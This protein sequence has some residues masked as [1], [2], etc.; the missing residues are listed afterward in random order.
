MD[1]PGRKDHTEEFFLE[2]SSI[3][4]CISGVPVKIKKLFLSREP[5][6][7]SAAQEK[8]SVGKVKVLP[9]PPPPVFNCVEP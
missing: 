7:C 5:Q 4:K 9:E 3:I 6:R 1:L 8:S 2:D